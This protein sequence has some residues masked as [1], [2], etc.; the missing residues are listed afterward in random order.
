MLLGFKSAVVIC[1]DLNEIAAGLIKKVIGII[2]V[3]GV[4]FSIETLTGVGI[5]LM[6]ATSVPFDRFIWFVNRSNCV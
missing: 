6:S 3:R 4:T 2:S 5:I 1:D